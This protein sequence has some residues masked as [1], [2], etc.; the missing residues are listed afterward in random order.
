MNEIA[1]NGSGE[2]AEFP[3][4]RQEVVAMFAAVM[5]IF[6]MSMILLLPSFNTA[7]GNRCTTRWNAFLQR[8]EAWCDDGSSAVRRYNGWLRLVRRAPQPG[9]GSRH[10]TEAFYGN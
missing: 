2:L 6:T 10:T 7:A 5:L 4:G 9:S 8:A 3:T 1:A